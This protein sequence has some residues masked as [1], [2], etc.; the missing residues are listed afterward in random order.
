MSRAVC[1]VLAVSCGSIWN[2]PN[3]SCGM[4][5]PLDSLMSG[6]L[7]MLTGYPGPSTPQP[8]RS[9]RGERAE[10]PVRLH[11]GEGPE[12]GPV[13]G[14]LLV[15]AQVPAVLDDGGLGALPAFLLLLLLHEPGEHVAGPGAV[16]ELL[17]APPEDVVEDHVLERLAQQLLL[18]AALAHELPLG[19]DGEH[20]LHDGGVEEGHAG[21]EAVVHGGAVATL[22]VEL[23]QR[24]DRAD[25][26]GLEGVRRRERRVL[27]DVAVPGE[28]LVG[29][30]A[31]EHDLDVLDRLAGQQQVRLRPAPE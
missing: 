2:T 16:A 14:D 24:L 31:G 22:Q 20:L 3:P 11:A 26:L 6:T 12:P 7:L 10:C 8:A 27:V 23:V 29:P 21:L 18:G 13:V 1:T 5:A 9:R 4:V 15:A 30:L 17:L 25:Q 19:G 28:E